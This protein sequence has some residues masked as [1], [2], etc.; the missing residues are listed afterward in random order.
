MP[1]IDVNKKEIIKG[2]MENN[3][4]CR[5]LICGSM[6]TQPFYIEVYGKNIKQNTSLID[7]NGLYVPNHPHLTIDEID[8]I[9]E[10]IVNSIKNGK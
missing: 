5:P 1:I 9:S 7:K 8:R 6:G 3:I 4:E 2:L 10:I